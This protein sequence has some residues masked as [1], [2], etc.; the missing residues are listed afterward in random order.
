MMNLHRE[1]TRETAFPREPSIIIGKAD[2]ER[3][4]AVVESNLFGRDEEAAERL[5]AELDR[6]IVVPQDAVP[7][8]I[9]TMASRVVFEDADTG[10]TREITLS[11]PRDA[12]P[13]QGRISILAPVGT[14][15]LGLGVGESIDWPLPNGRTGT[16][17]IAAV[18][19]QAADE[20]PD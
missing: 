19:R 13:S 9:V 20:E 1:R 15:L 16:F 6:A 17:R 5:G 11:E 7:P 10:R 14:A 4:R 12:D 3:L 2:L 8:E 18:N